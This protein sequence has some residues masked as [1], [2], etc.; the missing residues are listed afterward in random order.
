MKN[1]ILFLGAALL[2]VSCDPVQNSWRWYVKNGTEQ[3]L[4][5]RYPYYS[6][7]AL[8]YQIF[9]IAPGD[10]VS[11]FSSSFDSR[12]NLSFNYYFKKIIDNYGEDVHW[13]ISSESEEVLKTWNYLNRGLPD[14]RF[15]EK[16]LW[17]YYDIPAHGAFFDVRY[18]WVFEILPEDIND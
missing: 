6:I 7:H 16:S 2:C 5:L 11:I 3:T 18:S 10:S 12:N 4:I 14:Q 15:F 1:I 17:L 8:E 9:A 13:Q